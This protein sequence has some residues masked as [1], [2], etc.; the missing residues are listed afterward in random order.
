M[1]KL[2]ISLVSI[3]IAVEVSAQV[4]YGNYDYLNEARKLFKQGKFDIA[5]RTY[6]AYI[7]IENHNHDAT[8]EN[9][10]L[11][12]ALD[13]LAVENINEAQKFYDDYKTISESKDAIFEQRYSAT[14]ERIR[15]KADR[16]SKNTARDSLESAITE[17]YKIFCTDG[18]NVRCY[19]GICHERLGRTVEAKDLFADGTRHN[20]SY[21]PYRLAQRIRLDKQTIPQD[22][23]ISLY[24]RSA[25]KGYTSARDS[26]AMQYEMCGDITNADSWFGRSSSPLALYKRACYIMEGRSNS[27]DSPTELLTQ[28]ANKDYPQ[29]Q[30]HLGMLYRAGIHVPQNSAEG[31]KW[32]KKAA[33]AGH[34]K[35]K[36]EWYNKSKYKK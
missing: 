34:K 33:D 22:S 2:I 24:R 32:I 10:W 29:A 1:K 28:A 19:A 25:I 5:R 14:V 7:N 3:L 35:A 8:F 30:Y 23:L 13:A 31:W 12:K 36:T 15:Q 27:S 4:Q 9:E 21:A 17:Y 18:D 16:L 6:I 26:L 20:E 11:K